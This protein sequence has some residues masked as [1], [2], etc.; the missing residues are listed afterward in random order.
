MTNYIPTNLHNMIVVCHSNYYWFA[1]VFFPLQLEAKRISTPDLYWWAP[2]W[3]PAHC[4]PSSW[5]LWPW[6]AARHWWPACWRWCC[7]PY[8]RWRNWRPAA[9]A[10]ADT[11]GPRTRWSTCRRTAD[12]ARTDGR[13]PTVWPTACRWTRP[14]RWPPCKTHRPE[15][16]GL[17]L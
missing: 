9:A 16:R 6:W 8:W 4:C 10:A 5:E 11:A 13:W 15:R 1:R 17:T 14:S 7:P 12:T 3:W 2:W